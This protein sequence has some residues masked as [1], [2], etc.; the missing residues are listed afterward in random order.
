M[1]RLLLP[2]RRQRGFSLIVS[3]ILLVIVTLVA[4]ASM[5]S[6]ALESRMSAST[7]DRNLAFQGAETGLREAETRA[8]AATAGNFPG[9]GCADGYCAEPAA[10]DRARWAN[11]AFNGWRDTTAAVSDKA[12]TPGAIVERN[13]EGENWV[14]CGQEI[15]RQP[16][17]RTPR[18]RVTGRSAAD[19]RANVIL[20]SD[21]ATQ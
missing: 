1:K 13:G 4:L 10:G 14:A 9:A 2:R 8:A 20:Q 12:T 11:D 16:N 15:P 19:G 7:F 6:V 17:C 21:V 5:R 18:Y 3:L